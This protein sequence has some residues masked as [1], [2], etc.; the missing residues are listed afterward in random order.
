M[1]DNRHHFYYLI[2]VLISLILLIFP[3]SSQIKSAFHVWFIQF[4]RYFLAILKMRWILIL[5]FLSF[6]LNFNWLLLNVLFVLIIT[7]TPISTL[8]IC[9]VILYKHSSTS[10]YYPQVHFK[11]QMS[12]IKH[13]NV[14]LCSNQYYALQHLIFFVN[15]QILALK[16]AD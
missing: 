15:F 9:F 6:Y 7:H 16:F 4:S 3:N 11:Q 10:I 14:N 1:T 13:L 8:I 2:Q 12:M 5:I